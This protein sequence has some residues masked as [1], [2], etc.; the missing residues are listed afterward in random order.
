M[1]LVQY[2]VYVAAYSTLSTLVCTFKSWHV[3]VSEQVKR[4]ID[5]LI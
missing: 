2:F 3:F 4:V 1:E 5:K